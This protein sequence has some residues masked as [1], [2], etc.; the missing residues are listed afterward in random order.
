MWKGRNN[1]NSDK[2]ILHLY[3][4][5]G[6]IAFLLTLSFLWVPI[7]NGNFLK[8]F[9]CSIL[10][11]LSF[12]LFMWRN[13]GV[14]QFM[15]REKLITMCYSDVIAFGSLGLFGMLILI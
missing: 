15:F 14:K 2:I 4:G 6:F 11:I 3:A 13:L 10:V 9:I 7:V 12:A 5:I 1:M 8:Y